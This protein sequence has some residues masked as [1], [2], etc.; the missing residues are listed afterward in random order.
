MK[1]TKM[2]SIFSSRFILLAVLVLHALVSNAV[3]QEK[4]FSKQEQAADKARIETDKAIKKYAKTAPP[5]VAN[6]SFRNFVRGGLMS[7]NLLQV[8]YV[9]NVNLSAGYFGDAVSPSRIIWPRGSGVEYGHTMSFLVAGK[10]KAED[11]SDLFIISD[12]YNRSGGDQSPDGSHKFFFNT[13]PGF[14]NM[15]GDPG[16]NNRLN[17]NVSD[18]RLLDEAGFYYVGGLNEDANGNGQLDEGE[19]LNQNEA[20]DT[21]L[22]NYV[23]Y[24]AQSNFKETW[25]QFWPPK[26]YVGDNRAENSFVPGVRA[27]RWNGA[28]GSF[29]R[30]DQE[31]YYKADD[32]DNDEFEYY[33]FLDETTGL[34]DKRSW[35]Q[36]GRRGLGVE[37]SV[38]QYQWASVLAEDIL[39]ATFDVE[40]VSRFDIPSTIISMMVDYDI[41]GSTGDNQA[42]FD[43]VDDITYQW[44]KRPL[45]INGFRVGYAGVGF[46]ESP[47]IDTDGIDNDRDNLVDES[48]ENGIDDDNDW[49]NWIDVNGNGKYDNEDL[50]NN[51]RL[52]EGED[53]DGD[54]K[55]TIEPINDDVGSD[56]LGPFDE[57]YPGP[58]PD[59]SEANGVA[60]LGEPNFEFTDND[61]IDQIGLTNMVIRT[62]SDFDRDLDDDELFWRDYIQ[63]VAESEFVVPTE[64]ADVIYVYSSGTTEIKKGNSQRFSLAFFCGNDF[65]DML[66]NKRT[67]QNI[68][69]ADYNFARPP[70]EP[71]LTA[72]SGNKRTT[73]VWEQSAESSRDPIYGF[74]FEMYKVYRSTDP[75]FNEIKT[76]TDAFGNPLLWEPLQTAT[77]DKAQFDLKNGLSGAHPV[78]VEGFGV[79]YDM[80]AD[81]GLKYSFVDS[82]VENGRTY[83]YAVVSVDQGYHSSFFGD[84]ISEYENLA[85]ISPTESAKLIEIDAFDRPINVGQNCAVVVPQAAAAGYLP[86][87]LNEEG[88]QYPSGNST[89]ALNIDFLVPEDANRENYTYEFSFTDDNR[90]FIADSSYLEHG[91]TNGFTLKNLTTNEVLTTVSGAG[92]SLFSGVALSGTLYDGMRFSISNPVRPI[93]LAGDWL[94]NAAQRVRS[95]VDMSL[96]LNG[97]LDIPKDF[98]IRVG[99]IGV[100]TADGFNAPITNFELFDVTNL[101]SPIRMVYSLTDGAAVVP[102]DTVRG[103]LSPGDRVTV[104]IAPVLSFTGRVLYTKS[105]WSFDI[106]LRPRDEDRMQELTDGLVALY[107]SLGAYNVRGFGSRPFGPTLTINEYEAFVKTIKPWFENTLDSLNSIPA[108]AAFLPSLSLPVET[109]EEI[110][111]IN[112]AYIPRT[113][114]TYYVKT[115]KPLTR[116][117]KI[118]FSV[119]GNELADTLD[120]SLLDNIYTVPDPYVGVNNLERRNRLL[121]GRSERRIDFRNLPTNCTIKIFTVNGRLVKTLNHQAGTFDSIASWNMQSE[122][123]L[124]VAFGVYIYH[125]DAP[126]IGEKIGRLSIIK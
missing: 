65:N 30:G 37:V 116:A 47:G 89:A 62:P 64:T 49:R 90:Y 102:G 81:S 75:E 39:I 29:V 97:A 112:E 2:I 1:T 12:S 41:A 9:T 20:L 126:G 69:D 109:L 66:R 114:D 94:G 5:S 46:L 93:P 42:L 32:R 125:V 87:R 63:P 68:Y 40:N 3:A 48:R 86:A 21:E 4:S 10:V 104:R 60:N 6:L 82:T 11:G 80:G 113:N 7:G 85:E 124:E 74:D 121:S 79:S 76:I 70:R 36:G 77:G 58:D 108:F 8:P 28:Y 23:E 84:G 95:T 110:L 31:A 54:G 27:G 91:L 55:V 103:M 72:I 100:D 26:S 99:T 24:T 83:Y 51:F 120:E 78:S 106:G 34:P 25:P 119:Q 123:G 19:D 18:R 53:L 56:G 101:N 71:F 96:Q 57:N 15:N 33:P 107:D 52:D 118:Q 59:G 88:I 38:R 92:E 117:D 122:D 61:E 115:A 14:Y 43:T 111:A 67:M 50:N 73:L 17:N 45:V 44:I 16:T 13:L 105:A 22:V 35:A 98:E